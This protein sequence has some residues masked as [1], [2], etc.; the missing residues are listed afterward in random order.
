MKKLEI[1][2]VAENRRNNWR[3]I[4]EKEDRRKRKGE[5]I[6]DFSSSV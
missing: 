3:K 6:R 2:R 1:I 4:R 5:K